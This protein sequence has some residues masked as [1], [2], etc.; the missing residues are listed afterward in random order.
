MFVIHYIIIIIFFF[1]E[2]QNE[3]IRFFTLK[4][5][6]QSPKCYKSKCLY[7]KNSLKYLENYE[8]SQIYWKFNNSKLQ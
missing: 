7:N 3:K 2:T 5:Y 4:G 1:E 8:N 6:Y